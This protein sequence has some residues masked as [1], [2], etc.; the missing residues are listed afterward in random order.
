MI[1]DFFILRILDKNKKLNLDRE[2]FKHFHIQV[3]TV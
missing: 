2:M 1:I 3:S